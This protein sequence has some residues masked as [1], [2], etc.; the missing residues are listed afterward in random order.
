MLWQLHLV[1]SDIIVVQA[2]L[3][4]TITVPVMPTSLQADCPSQLPSVRVIKE[5]DKLKYLA[6]WVGMAKGNR[7]VLMDLEL[8][9]LSVIYACNATSSTY[10]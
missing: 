4:E 9:H 3:D 6:I 2:P 10:G 5:L 8:R 7:A 1:D